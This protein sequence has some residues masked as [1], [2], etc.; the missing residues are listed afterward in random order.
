MGVSAEIRW[1]WTDDSMADKLESWFNVS[2]N[3]I[4]PL[5]LGAPA[6]VDAYVLDLQQPR[7][8]IKT[9]SV[10]SR[11]A[12]SQTE[13]KGLVDGY[14][15]RLDEDA[16][17]GTI[18]L[19]S[20]WSA[21]LDLSPHKSISVHKQRYMRRF[22]FDERSGEFSEFGMSDEERATGELKPPKQ[23]CNI[24]FT[25]VKIP[26]IDVTASSF[27]FEAFGQVA[28]VVHALKSTAKCVAA[29]KPPSLDTGLIASYPVWLASSLASSKV[30]L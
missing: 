3:G 2:W 30:T 6:R 21:A 17:K 9:R 22:K 11:R 29:T 5:G 19:W 25:R 8:S 7:L 10:N 20:K 15:D 12:Q 16:F 26:M 4:H 18:E 23:G 28:N 1:F 24:E 14:F 13:I 27:A